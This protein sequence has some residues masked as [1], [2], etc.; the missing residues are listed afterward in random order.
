MAKPVKSAKVV[1]P[2]KVVKQAFYFPYAGGKKDEN[3]ELLSIVTPL[4]GKVNKVVEVF[5]GSLSFS[6]WMYGQYGNQL[7]Y[8]CSDVDAD[9]TSFCNI[10]PTMKQEVLS[11]VISKSDA[12]QASGNTKA[13]FYEFKASK[14]TFAESKEKM[15]WELFFR[16]NTFKGSMGS[17]PY[18][19][20]SVFQNYLKTT[21]MADEFFLSNEYKCQDFSEYLEQVKDDPEAL[22]YLDPPYLDRNNGWYK[23]KDLKRIFPYLE[24][25]MRT[26]K[27]KYIFV[28]CDHPTLRSW[29]SAM[30]CQDDNPINIIKTYTKK[31]SVGKKGSK[32][33]EPVEHIVISN[34]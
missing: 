8:L 27:C 9:L 26:C 19:K 21:T 10:F 17:Y 14:P 28:H 4:I 1:K 25:W 20:F 16:K 3:N 2:A 32:A 15:V 11:E 18:K 6:R 31:Y 22:V 13:E 30:I 23:S 29:C 34:I 33:K 7:E 24:N 5:G 12:M